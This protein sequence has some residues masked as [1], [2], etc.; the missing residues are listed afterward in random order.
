MVMAVSVRMSSVYA[1]SNAIGDKL[2]S[3][4]ERGKKEGFVFKENRQ[5]VWVHLDLH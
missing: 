1:P 2:T 5:D 3:V 4:L